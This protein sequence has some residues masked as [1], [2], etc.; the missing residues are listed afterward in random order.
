MYFLY[1][2][3]LRIHW[4]Q[5]EQHGFTTSHQMLYCKLPGTAVILKSEIGENQILKDIA[6]RISLVNS[7]ADP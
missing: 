5:K 1:Y 3:T 6:I 2:N 7:V 4:K